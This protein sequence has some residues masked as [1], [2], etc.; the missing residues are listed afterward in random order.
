MGLPYLK[1]TLTYCVQYIISTSELTT[2]RRLGEA[3]RAKKGHARIATVYDVLY[4]V[5]IRRDII[6]SPF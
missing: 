1:I 6:V 2:L 4:A 3:I 5:H